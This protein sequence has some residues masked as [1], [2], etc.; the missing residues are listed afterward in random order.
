MPLLA[1]AAA[2]F[3]LACGMAAWLG[4]AQ[5]QSGEVSIDSTGELT[6]H[7]GQP[8]LPWPT[9]NITIQDVIITVTLKPCPLCPFMRS[10]QHR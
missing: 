4:T 10:F 6:G 2:P 3:G 8:T 5:A 1:F 9:Q 7:H